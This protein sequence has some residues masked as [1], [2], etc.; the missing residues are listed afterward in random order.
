M[1][2][3]DAQAP[4][5]VKESSHTDNV[6]CL[7]LIGNTRVITLSTAEPLP[8]S[9]PVYF[10]YRAG[11]FYF[12]SNP[13]A[14]HV[15]QGTGRYVSA[16]L[17]YDDPDPLRIEGLQMSGR[18][19]DC[20][21]NGTSKTTWGKDATFAALAYALRFGISW[22]GTCLRQFFK[23]RYHAGLFRFVPETAWYMN[24]QKGMGHRTHVQLS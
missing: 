2:N 3:G 12:F 19:E 17:F 5:P 18:I 13:N 21:K 23:L 8:W 1:S 16:S 6:D 10:V 14:R 7:R 22:E 24:N 20:A 9:A 15:V 4:F 11:G